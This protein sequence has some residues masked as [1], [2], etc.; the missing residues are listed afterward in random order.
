M[1]EYNYPS[2]ISHKLEH[3]RHNKKIAEYTVQLKEGIKSL[4]LE[5]LKSFKNWFTN[6]FDINDKKLSE[7]LYSK[8]IR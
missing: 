6:H 5:F 3:E 4:D 2:Y 1:K 8:G 7:F